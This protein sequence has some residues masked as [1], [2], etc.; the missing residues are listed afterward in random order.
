MPLVYWVATFSLP[1][2][3][4]ENP[5]DPRLAGVILVAGDRNTAAFQIKLDV[6]IRVADKTLPHSPNGWLA[7]MRIKCR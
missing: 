6:L 2:G 5:S 3:G 7:V 1:S 4:V